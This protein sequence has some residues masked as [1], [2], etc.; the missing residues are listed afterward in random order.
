MQVHVGCSKLCCVG[1]GLGVRAS[2]LLGVQISLKLL[3]GRI[4]VGRGILGLFVNQS[5]TDRILVQR[6]CSRFLLLFR[7]GLEMRV[8][9]WVQAIQA[10][11]ASRAR[12]RCKSVTSEGLRPWTSPSISTSPTLL[13]AGKNTPTIECAPGCD[14]SPGTVTPVAF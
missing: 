9:R 2:E 10:F 4:E 11:Q 1:V 3:V 14:T 5:P 8:L 13:G 12:R 6:G 7:F